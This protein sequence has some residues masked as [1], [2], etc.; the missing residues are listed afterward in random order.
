MPSQRHL[1][2]N[3]TD[4]CNDKFSFYVN[5]KNERTNNKKLDYRIFVKTSNDII[6]GIDGF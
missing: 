3:K 1:Q 6:A 2:V 4:I 5:E